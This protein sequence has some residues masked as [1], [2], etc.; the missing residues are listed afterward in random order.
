VN[1]TMLGHLEERLRAMNAERGATFVVIEHNMD[2]VMRLCTRVVVLAEGK[3]IAEGTPAEVR[4]NQAVIDAY[5]G[6]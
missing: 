2:F 1:L 3:K 5:L 4:A 6:H